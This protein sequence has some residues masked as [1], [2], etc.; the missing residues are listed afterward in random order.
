MMEN[1]MMSNAVNYMLNQWKLLDNFIK[2]GRVQIS[3]NLCEQRMKPV[4]L[5]LKNC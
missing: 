1:E 4:K 3:N 5:N 2:D